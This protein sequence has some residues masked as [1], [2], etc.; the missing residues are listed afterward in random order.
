MRERILDFV[1]ALRARGVEVSVAEALDAVR[2]VAA[3]GVEREVLREALAASLVKHE[4]DRPAFDALFEAMFPLVGADGETGGRRKRRARAGG[5]GAGTG[6]GGAGEGR[7]RRDERSD[8]RVPASRPGD[9]ARA[10]ETRGRAAR[11]RHLL[12]LPF[13]EFTSR[14]VEEARAL[15][16]ELGKRVRGRLARRARGARKGRLDF[17]RTIRA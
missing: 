5:D 3:A 4:A 17:R 16:E 7:G 11:T 10:G 8:R 15:V 13:R 12:A 6:R 9:A 1:Q 2:A 14:D